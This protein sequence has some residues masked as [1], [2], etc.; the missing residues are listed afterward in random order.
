MRQAVAGAMDDGKMPE[1]EL[2]GGGAGHA[3]A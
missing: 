2:S 3:G 1:G